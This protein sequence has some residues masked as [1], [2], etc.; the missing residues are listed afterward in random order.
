MLAKRISKYRLG[1]RRSALAKSQSQNILEA[2]LAEGI[3][4]ELVPIE[5]SGDEN[6]R[7]PL[8]EI[9]NETPGL[10]TKELETALLKKK[11]DLAVHSLKDLP[12]NQPSGLLVAAVTRR[13]WVSDC[14]ILSPTKVSPSDKFGVQSG[15]KLGTSSLRREAQWKEIRPDIEI[16]PI[17]GNVPTRVRMV[18]EGKIDGVILAEA[19]I[20]R[21]H[22][23][24]EG[25]LRS[26]LPPEVFISAPGQGALALE[27]REDA[28]TRLRE[29][30]QRL[31][32]GVTLTE[33]RIERRILKGLFGGCTLPLGVRCVWD[34]KTNLLNVRT[35]LG[36]RS[37]GGEWI[38]FHRFD[39]CEQEEETLVVNT[40]SHLGEFLHNAK[41]DL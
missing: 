15:A 4:C 3:L 30:L 12:T 25:V 39:I 40:V 9:E 11:I 20:Q 2:L 27:I 21:L 35:F 33:T 10:F 29:A 31:E 16:L 7:T 24:L 28:D 38:S 32:H 17:R 34:T 13:E 18:R 37:A 36:I 6:R 8:Y 41:R 14:L 23:S 5:S 26:V 1:T 19:G 22:L